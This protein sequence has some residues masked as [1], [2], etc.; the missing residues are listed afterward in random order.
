MTIRL[1]ETEEDKRMNIIR[2]AH[3]IVDSY[4]KRLCEYQ[5]DIEKLDKEIK[6]LNGQITNIDVKLGKKKEPYIRK[7][8]ILPPK[9]TDMESPYK[10]LGFYAIEPSEKPVKKEKTGDEVDES[11]ELEY[12]DYEEYHY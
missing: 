4:Q 7:K 11:V 1:M 8:V 2:E 6:D 5:L 12:Y 9:N 3:R 10:Y